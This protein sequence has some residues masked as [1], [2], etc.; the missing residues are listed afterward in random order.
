MA[1]TQFS[2]KFQNIN[3]SASYDGIT[4]FTP[5][6]SV[7]VPVGPGGTNTPNVGFAITGAGGNVAVQLP[8]GG[9]AT[10]TGLVTGQIVD[11]AVKRILATGTTAAG[12][13]PLYNERG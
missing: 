8:G 12:V 4:P 1:T 9:T 7:D 6:D 11:C 2:S 5:S 10:L 3:V 13:I